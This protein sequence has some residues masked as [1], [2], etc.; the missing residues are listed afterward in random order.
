[1]GNRKNIRPNK[2]KNFMY[3]TNRGAVN[4]NLGAKRN[5]PEQVKRNL[6]NYISPVQ[7][8]RLRTDISM[9]RDAI[10][11]AERA[12][13]PFRVKMQRIFIDTILDGHVYS[14]MERRKDLTILRKFSVQNKEKTQSDELTQ[15]F[16]QAPWFTDF[17]S[18]CLDALAFGYSLISLGDVVQ[19]EMKEVSIVPRW[20]V[21]PD[22]EDVSTFIYSPSGAA[23]REEPYNDWHVYAKTTSD[24]GVSPCGYG[25]LYQIARYEIFLRNTLGFNGDFVELYAMPYRVGKTT[26]TTESERYELEQAVKNMGSAGYAIVDPMDEI[27]FLEASTAGTGYKAYDNLESRCEAKVSKIILGHADA[28][29][30]VPGKL[31]SGQ[32][33]DNP[34]AN[35]LEDKKLKD[36]RFVENIVNNELIPRLKKLGVVNVPDGYKFVFLNDGEAE[37]A[38]KAED[39][40]NLITAQ[41]AQ[42]MKNAG[43]QMDADYFT[44][45]TGITSEKI[46]APEPIKPSANDSDDLRNNGQVK[47]MLSELYS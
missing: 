31:G 14:L 21:S 45:R 9:W 25:Y 28:M 17:L 38:R 1:M 3:N 11:E 44:E 18:Y 42:T 24:S 26:K 36:G 19:S 27:Q 2:V 43:L 37:E 22:R 41:I 7:L 10:G 15:F 23:F 12:Y 46:E 32:G 16:E 47:N 30:S 5:D 20:F 40:A 34:V 13:W 33:Q 29:D 4:T 6:S 39:Q 8:Q 35:A